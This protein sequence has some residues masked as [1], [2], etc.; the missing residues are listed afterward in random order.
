MLKSYDLNG[1]LI[2]KVQIAINRLKNFEPPEGYFVAFSGGKDSQ[3]I[4]HLCEMAGVKFDAHYHV[5]SVDPPQLVKFV[6]KQYPNVHF[7]IPHDENG[8]PIT[9]W[10]LIPEKLIP[11][12]RLKRYCCEILKE[13]SSAG[14]VTVTGVRWSESTNRKANQDVV[15]IQGKTK[16]AKEVAEKVEAKYR[17]SPRGG[18]LLNDD[19]DPSRRMV[20][21]CY[22]TH[23]TLV[24]PI[25]DWSEEDVWEFLNDIAKVPHCQ[26]YDEGYK[27]LG[28]IGCPMSY[29]A[30]FELNANPAFKNAYLRAFGRLIKERIRRGLETTWD[31][32][33]DVMKWWLDRN[34]RDRELE[35]QTSLFDMENEE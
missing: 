19:N 31:T 9:M 33:Q 6:R 10:N 1:N 13:S 24:N 32:P 3:C 25:V 26:L 20:E 27:R 4:Y 12:T 29:N 14:R 16:K 28:C 5:T 30:E 21:H 7:E 34:K 8:K 15:N 35:G 17:Q 18:L 11:P 23:E 2:D 22:R